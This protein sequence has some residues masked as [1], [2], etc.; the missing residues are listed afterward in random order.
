[1]DDFWRFIFFGDLFPKM[2]LIIS[3]KLSSAIFTFREFYG[4]EK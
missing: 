2:R 3:W 4:S 1:M